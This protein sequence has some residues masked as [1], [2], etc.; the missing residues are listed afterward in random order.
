MFFP[1][2][3]ED[4]F[5]EHPAEQIDPNFSSSSFPYVG[6]EITAADIN[7]G[8]VGARRRKKLSTAAENALT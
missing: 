6:G 8:G 3:K 2:E 4:F 7:R 5:L 1:K